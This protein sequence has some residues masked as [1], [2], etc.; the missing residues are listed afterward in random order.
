LQAPIPSLHANTD[1]VTS[2]RL[3]L[4]RF[5]A[6]DVA[7]FHL[8]LSDPQA[9]RYWSTPPH[10]DVAETEI[11]IAKTIAAVAAGEADDFI[12]E[13]QGRVIGKAGL[14]SGNELGMIFAPSCWGQ[15]FASEAVRAIIAR[16]FAQGRPAIT[17]DVDPRNEKSLR[18]LTRLGFHETG[19]ALRTLKVGEEWVDSVYLEL[20]AP[21]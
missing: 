17:A 21:T 16:A 8:I 10:R 7:V 1:T 11:W 12:A 5:R 19:R 18:L 3:N 13:H 14:W 6:E 9:M 2:A 15:G 4:R 20:K